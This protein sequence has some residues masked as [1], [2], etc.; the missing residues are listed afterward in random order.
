MVLENTTKPDS[1][2]FLIISNPSSL[3]NK[4][5]IT[6]STLVIPQDT[7]TIA[8]IHFQPLVVII[9]VGSHHLPLAFVFPHQQISSLTF[10]TQPIILHD[11]I[12]ATVKSVELKD[13]L[14]SATLHYV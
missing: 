9:W 13:I 11:L 2:Y 7:P 14:P 4:S 8:N 12:L 10:L 5:G 1:S 3:T 6:C